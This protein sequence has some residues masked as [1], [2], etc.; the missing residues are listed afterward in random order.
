MV[1]FFVIVA[2]HDSQVVSQINFIIMKI[3]TLPIC[4]NTCIM[5]IFAD[6]FSKGNKKSR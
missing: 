1:A 6:Y 2:L 3:L 5:I 4:H